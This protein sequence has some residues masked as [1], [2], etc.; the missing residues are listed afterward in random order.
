MACEDKCVKVFVPGF[1]FAGLIKEAAESERISDGFLLGEHRTKICNQ[2]SDAH[3]IGVELEKELILHTTIQNNKSFSYYDNLGDVFEKQ[4]KAIFK[5]QAE[6]VIGIYFIRKNTRS[7]LSLR[8]KSIIKNM[9]HT[10]FFCHK[11]LLV[12][13]FTPHYESNK[14]THIFSY[15]SFICTENGVVSVSTD[16][17]NLG[18]LGNL[19]MQNYALKSRLLGSESNPRSQYLKLLQEEFR[20]RFFSKTGSVALAD[21]AYSLMYR[22]LFSM[23][24]LQEQIQSSETSILELEELLNKSIQ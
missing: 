22:T 21:N 5:T 17:I 11:F 8:E 15:K 16:I 13:L 9:L 24:E 3:H 14:A 4:L 23:K 18:N 20:D 19:E 6:M 10:D 2:I 1:V 7:S 12:L